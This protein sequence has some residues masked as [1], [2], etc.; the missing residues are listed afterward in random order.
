MEAHLVKLSP[1]IR[2]RRQAV[3]AH[4]PLAVHQ[5][6]ATIAPRQPQTPGMGN[7]APASPAPNAQPT[8][9]PTPIRNI[10]NGTTGE[11]APPSSSTSST[12]SPPP[13]SGTIPLN[14]TLPSGAPG[15]PPPRGPP[16]LGADADATE[17]AAPVNRGMVMIAGVSAAGVCYLFFP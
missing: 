4:I 3:P 16:G 1:A 17:P 15:A 5:R 7:P 10:V 13:G 11:N 8:A 9:L 12:P 2:G 14:G 6:T